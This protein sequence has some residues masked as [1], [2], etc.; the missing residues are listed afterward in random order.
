MSERARSHSHLS[1]L[2][3]VVRRRCPGRS[4]VV[5]RIGFEVLHLLL[6]AWQPLSDSSSETDDDVNGAGKREGRPPACHP[7][8]AKATF[9]GRR[10]MEG[11]KLD[12]LVTSQNII[13]IH[14]RPAPI[15]GMV[16]HVLIST[17]IPNI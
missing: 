12:M 3:S 4:L 9:L 5:A 14:G 6:Y 10:R 1:F 15:G 8:V 13:A 16:S 7:C 2:H 11:N 17:S